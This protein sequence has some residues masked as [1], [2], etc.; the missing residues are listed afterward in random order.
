[1]T[2]RLPLPRGRPVDRL[3]LR[4]AQQLRMLAHAVLGQIEAFEGHSRENAEDR[5]R[6]LLI[7]TE[8]LKMGKV[9]KRAAKR[10]WREWRERQR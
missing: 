4:D 3:Y 7:Q 1:M 2:L 9:A 6:F 8:V 5:L 10:Y